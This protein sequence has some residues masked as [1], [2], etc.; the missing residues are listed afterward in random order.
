MPPL[1]LRPNVPAGQPDIV[2]NQ[3][4]VY[5]QR[6]GAGNP[7][8]SD[9]R[10]LTWPDGTPVT[11]QDLASFQ[12]YW[13]S[14]NKYRDTLTGEATRQFNV[15][16]NQTATSENNRV[17]QAKA[18]L[19]EQQR[20]Y[21]LTYGQDQQKINNQAQQFGVNTAL[22]ITKTG[23]TMRGPLDAFQGEAY[24]RGIQTNGLAP[25]LSVLQGGGVP[26]YGGATATTANP[27]PLTVGTLANTLAGGGAS[28]GGAPPTASG[29]GSVARPAATDAYGRPTLSAPYQANLDAIDTIAKKGLSNLPLG[30]WENLSEAE[31]QSYISGSD[32][33]GRDTT[34]ELQFRQ[35]SRPGQGSAVAA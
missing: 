15:G 20:Q 29:V 12:A 19:K 7:V 27:T 10:P 5:P 13:A 34:S 1:P 26:G 3:T 2:P 18:A 35:R 11:Q 23:A 31:K 17:A 6:S 22:D 4:D 9:G 32:Y 21:D 25:Y 33:L 30:A 8:G 16:A 28:A 14:Q 24:A